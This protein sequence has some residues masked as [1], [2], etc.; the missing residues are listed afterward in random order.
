MGCALSSHSIITSGHSAKLSPVNYNHRRAPE[1]AD[2]PEKRKMTA[3]E[4]LK[5]FKDLAREAEADME[6]EAF[7]GLI[8]G[9]R[10]IKPPTKEEAIEAHRK[11]K[12]EGKTE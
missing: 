10:G 6:E 2:M 1:E 8:G 12:R 7:D 5:A 9:A 11:A 4:Q 3:Q